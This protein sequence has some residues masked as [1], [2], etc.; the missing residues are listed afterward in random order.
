M[1]WYMP[2]GSSVPMLMYS[3][4]YW[5]LIEVGY[6]SLSRRSPGPRPEPLKPPIQPKS[7]G[8]SRPMV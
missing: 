6:I 1:P 3:R 5:S 8:W 2:F 4:W 7:S